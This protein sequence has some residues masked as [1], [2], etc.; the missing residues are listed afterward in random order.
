MFAGKDDIMGALRNPELTVSSLV[1]SEPSSKR[2]PAGKAKTVQE[3]RSREEIAGKFTAGSSYQDY[4]SGWAPIQRL[5]ICDGFSLSSGAAWWSLNLYLIE[6]LGRNR[7]GGAL[8]VEIEIN[9]AEASLLCRTSIH[10]INLVLAQ[11]AERKLAIVSHLAGGKALIRFVFVPE[12]ISGTKYPGWHE[13]ASVPHEDWAREKAAA[14]RVEAGEV[15]EEADE[16]EEQRVK[17]GVVALTRKPRKVRPGQ[18]EKPLPVTTGVKSYR[19]DLV[20]DEKAVDVSYMAAVHSGE[21]VAT[22]CIPKRKP[23]ESKKVA[24]PADSTRY[25]M[26]S[27]RTCPESEKIPANAGSRGTPQTRVETST[28]VRDFLRGEELVH[29]FDPIL[30]KSCHKSLSADHFALQACSEAIRDVPHDVLVKRVIERASRPINSPRAC[31][32]I[33]LEIEANWRRVK[34]LPAE[35]KLPTR[36]EILEMARL[37]RI[38]RRK[39]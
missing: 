20:E 5:L 26:S 19:M 27:G 34:D 22:V 16:L 9:K 7:K 2:K 33:C 6:Q 15:D 31:V 24:K 25:D 36:E 1:E 18:P 11:M 30:L 23:V 32:A 4:S 8:P 39:S 13:V 10:N 35:K 29:L 21:F 17:R 37:E 12:L 14:L 28:T 3:I 38:A